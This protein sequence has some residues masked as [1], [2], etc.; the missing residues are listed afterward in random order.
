MD[1]D[2]KQNPYD[3][4]EQQV[5]DYLHEITGGNI[6]GGDDPVGF[7]IA[8]HNTLRTL[9]KSVRAAADDWRER[10]RSADGHGVYSSHERSI[11]AECARKI[12][13]IFNWEAK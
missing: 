1:R 12:E 9:N 4:H 6:G 13:K 7:L 3:E 5:A 10:A 8:S 11:F 2:I